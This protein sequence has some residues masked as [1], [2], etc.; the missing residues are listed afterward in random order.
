MDFTGTQVR[1]QAEQRRTEEQQ[2]RQ[3]MMRKQRLEN[4]LKEMSGKAKLLS[5]VDFKS[6]ESILDLDYFSNVNDFSVA[7]LSITP[8]KRYTRI[9]HE[10]LAMALQ[11]S[12]YVLK[13]NPILRYAL[14]LVALAIQPNANET[15]EIQ[16]ILP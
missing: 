1:T 9:S 2:Q 10:I 12:L 3:E 16:I 7:G 11:M 8:S 15:V 6:N 5:L 4:V 13:F 14:S